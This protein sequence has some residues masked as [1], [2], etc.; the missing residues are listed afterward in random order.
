MQLSSPELGGDDHVLAQ[1][2][3]RGAGDR[4]QLGGAGGSGVDALRNVESADAA[5]HAREL[6]G[7][8]PIL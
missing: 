5:G 7:L 2:D 3:L 1:Y 6:C 4:S 8:S